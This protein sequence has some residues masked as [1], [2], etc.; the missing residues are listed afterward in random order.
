MRSGIELKEL[1]SD[2]Q[3]NKAEDWI[4]NIACAARSG[5]EALVDKEAL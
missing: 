1:T 3:Q 2:R 5:G 4:M